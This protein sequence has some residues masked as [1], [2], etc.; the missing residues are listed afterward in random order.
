MTQEEYN[1]IENREMSLNDDEALLYTLRG[2][3]SGDKLIFNDYELNIKER[4]S[5][6]EYEGESSAVLSNSYYIVV[7]SLDIIKHVHSALEGNNDMPEM[8][9]YYGFDLDADSEIQINLTK[10]IR[11]AINNEGIYAHV[12]GAESQRTEFYSL[13]GGLF[14]IG[15]FIG[16]LFIIATVLIIYYK[17]TAEGFDDKKRFEIMQKVGMSKREIKKSIHSQVLMV[18]F[19]PLITAIIHIAFAFNVVT[20]MLSVFNL[21]NIPLY[22]ICTAVTIIVFALFYIIVYILTARTYYR[23]VR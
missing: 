21:T 16:L 5:S 10:S 6:F 2:E 7:N 13:Y 19:L 15:L 11:D 20:K 4:L 9:Y 1:K 8:S 23:I 22:A 17:Q 18:F 3:I 14:F 12:E